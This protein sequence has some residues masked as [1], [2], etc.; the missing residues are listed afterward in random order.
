MLAAEAPFD[1]CH[2]IGHA[3]PSHLFFQFARNDTSVAAEDGQRYFELANEP[4]QI[5]WYDN[6][7]HE[8]SAQAHLDRVIWLCAQFGLPRPSQDILDLLEQVPSQVP[9]ES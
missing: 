2:Y 6:C 9:L 5:N 3:A 7:N 8:L 4:K 1:A